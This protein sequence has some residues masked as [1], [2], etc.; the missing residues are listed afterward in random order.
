[1]YKYADTIRFIK[2]YSYL[3]SNDIAFVFFLDTTD[4][5][6]NPRAILEDLK[7]APEFKSVQLIKP[8]KEGLIFDTY[9]FPS[10][11]AGEKAIIF[12][13]PEYV[14][15]KELRQKYGPAFNAILYH[16]GFRFGYR[17]YTAHA[18]KYG[19]DPDTIFMITSENAKQLGYGIFEVI[20]YTSR[21]AIVRVYENFECYLFKK[22]NKLQ[23]HFV[24][25]MIAGFLAAM[26]N[27]IMEDMH[28]EETACI[29]TGS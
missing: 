15:Y 20:K 21:E 12:R 17:S 6:V 18:E 7:A 26:W 13:K 24:R 22:A 23:S 3:H 8:V 28:A 11:Y 25:G 16:V 29:A 19:K 27:L 14:S 5:K 2:I 10:L 9:S 4:K 1:M